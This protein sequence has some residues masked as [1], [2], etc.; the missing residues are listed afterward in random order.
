MKGRFLKAFKRTHEHF[1]QVRPRVGKYRPP[2][3]CVEAEFGPSA[4]RILL[5]ITPWG[6]VRAF[7]WAA[8]SPSKSRAIAL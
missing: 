8:G 5:T 2:A 7:H 1:T 4:H 6:V 3:A